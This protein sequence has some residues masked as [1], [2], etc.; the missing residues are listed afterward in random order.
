[1][2]GEDQVQRIPSSERYSPFFALAIVAM[3][4]FLAFMGGVLWLAF[5]R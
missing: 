1:M 5:S 2:R 4:A 3:V